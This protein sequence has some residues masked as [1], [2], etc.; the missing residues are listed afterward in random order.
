MKEIQIKCPHCGEAF[1]VNQTEYAS[2]IDQI[3]TAEF[4]AEIERRMK[5]N[6]ATKRAEINLAQVELKQQFEEKLTEE[7]KKA[8]Q[9]DAQITQLKEQLKVAEQNKKLEMQNSIAQK[10]REIDALKAEIKGY[11]DKLQLAIKA[12]QSKAVE[13]AHAKDIEIQQLH[14]Q[15]Q[16]VQE[17]KRASLQTLKEQYS[18]ELRH[19]KEEIERYKDFRTRMSTK[20]VGESLEEH[21]SNEFNKMRPLFPNVTFEKDTDASGGTK[22]DFILRAYDDGIE[23]LSIMFEMKNEMDTTATKHKN[24]EFFKKLDS[25]RTKKGCEYAVLVSLLEADSELYN[26]GIVDVSHRYERMYVVRPQNFIPIITL[27]MNAA[28]KS[29]DYKRELIVARSQSVDISNFEDQLND[30]KTKF[31]RNYRLASEKFGSAIKHIDDT[32]SKLNKVK[33]DLLSSENNLRLANEKAEELTIKSLT[34]KNPTMRQLFEEA[35]KEKSASYEVLN[36]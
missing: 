35:K 3:K 4:D 30:F 16:A 20:M 8:F 22:G 9:K 7:L 6:E 2:V 26:T 23:Y 15:V 17:E 19:A 31:G 18:L 34:R 1:T 11:A 25:D 24:E 36:D 33:E 28:K 5:E 29:V 27:L 12:E 32:I 10:E 13:A 21:C 14:N